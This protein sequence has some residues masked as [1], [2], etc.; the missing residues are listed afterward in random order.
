MQIFQKNWWSCLCRMGVTATV[1][2]AQSVSLLA[3]NAPQ[4]R[5]VKVEKGQLLEMALEENLSSGSATEGQQIAFH[6]TEPL[7]ADGET[8]LPAGW[9]LTGRVTGV[10]KAG[11]NCKCGKLDWEI[12]DVKTQQGTTI[13]LR[14]AYA[15][16]EGD[17]GRLVEPDPPLTIREK[18][19][20][21]L[22]SPII[23]AGFILI[24]PIYVALTATDREPKCVGQG[25]EDVR[26]AGWISHAAVRRS[27]RVTVAGKTESGSADS[28]ATTAP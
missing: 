22:L 11:K 5:T 6:L 16:R 12:D 19:R 8:V 23:A 27:V 1:L 4:P 13:R 20:I 17:G 18:L 10:E 24:A 26:F 14:P 28:A 15:I 2:V 21:V 3:Q 7:V 9:K 25:R